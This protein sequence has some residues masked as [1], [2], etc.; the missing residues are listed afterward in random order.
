MARTSRNL[1]GFHDVVVRDIANRN[2][3]QTAPS[4]NIIQ[5][6]Y[7][8]VS[9]TTSN[10]SAA[11]VVSID[12]SQQGQWDLLLS[13]T[14]Q[15]LNANTITTN[16][17]AA[18]SANSVI[19]VRQA[20][21]TIRSANVNVGNLTATSVS[22]T[23]A[24][25][26]NTTS[27]SFVKTL[28]IPLNSLSLICTLS[29]AVSYAFELAVAQ[30]V[31]GS[32]IAKSYYGTV[33]FS[34]TGWKRLLP[35]S[36][37]GPSSARDWA[38]D[39]N[40]QGSTSYFRLVRTANVTMTSVQTLSLACTLKIHSPLNAV[41]VVDNTETGTD[42]VNLGPFEGTLVTQVKGNVG[43]GTDSP[44]SMLDVAGNAAI[45]GSLS[46]T[47]NVSETAA[48]LWTSRLS[49][50]LGW[51]SVTYGGGLWVAVSNNSSVADGR[52][53]TSPDGIDCCCT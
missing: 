13:G 24:V 15:R 48:Y 44:T 49:P 29:S 31:S 35:L 7:S 52:I 51:R 12:G 45:A 21:T 11:E 27:R 9:G 42:A 41:V 14:T 5:H 26:G 38:V 3:F 2:Q 23:S 1:D 19:S 18:W 39:I 30:N 22:A 28:E 25:I 10:V 43:I 46:V 40:V 4:A 8:H 34:T 33:Q 36:S 17:T 53:M 6:L 50:E 32:A 47:G 37:T 16:N 20:S